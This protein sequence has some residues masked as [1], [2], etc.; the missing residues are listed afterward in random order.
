MAPSLLNKKDVSGIAGKLSFDPQAPLVLESPGSAGT[1]GTT[2][3]AIT[4]S[5]ITNAALLRAELERLGHHWEDGGDSALVAHAYAEWGPACVKRLRGAFACA[6]WDDAARRLVLARD[7]MG[8]RPLFYALLPERGVV[9]ASELRAVLGD[10]HVGAEWSAPAIDAYLALGYVPAPL[11]PYRRISKLEPAQLIVIEGR[12]LRSEQYWDVSAAAAHDADVAESDSAEALASGL[13]RSVRALTPATGLLYSG[14]PASTALLAAWPR[15]RRTPVTVD[16][17]QDGTELARSLNA[18]AHLGR[19]R[20]LDTVTT[21][22][23]AAAAPLA[24]SLDAPLADPSAVTRF[25][26]SAAVARHTDTACAG[27]GA[28]ALWLRAEPRPAVWDGFLRREIYTR[29]FG[30]QLRDTA[31]P[32]TGAHSFLAD[33]TLAA[34]DRTMTATG[35]RLEFP[36]LERDLVELAFAVA[37]AHK[38]WGHRRAFVLQ[39][40]LQRALPRPLV[41]ALTRYRPHPWLDATVA[42]MVP[43]ILLTP[44]F[45]G[46]GIVSRLALAELWQEHRAGRRDHARRLWALV[47]LECWF[48]ACVD[49][50]AAGE[51]LEYA[52]LV[53]VA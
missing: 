23:A 42:A 1:A 11:T 4:D 9:F 33:S 21:P 5:H 34:A 37:H 25:A 43:A 40:L 19:A 29:D 52:A 53:R 38:A 41:P 22:L 12:R 10:P 46:R 24:A 18:A 44:R 48:R 2:I 17:D 35:V 49:G 32:Q 7:H 6:I 3:R 15:D 20:E 13:R 8:I 26:V 16:V 31:P 14:G 30:W 50:S 51:P 28:A 36:F 47:M 39:Q 45:D 27:H